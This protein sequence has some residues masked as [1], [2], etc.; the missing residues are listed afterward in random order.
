MAFL[1]AVERV[2]QIL[3]DWFSAVEFVIAC[4]L[5]TPLFAPHQNA[6]CR[7]IYLTRINK[8]K[9]RYCGDKTLKIMQGI[10]PMDL[11]ATYRRIPTGRNQVAIFAIGLRCPVR[12]FG[13]IH[14]NFCKKGL[15]VPLWGVKATHNPS[16]GFTHP[17]VFVVL[18]HRKIFP[19]TFNWLLPTLPMSFSRWSPLFTFTSLSLLHLP[20]PMTA[21]HGS[22]VL[23]RLHLSVHNEQRSCL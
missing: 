21:W 16:F 19:Y 14:L 8:H 4:R 22:K 10:C 12:G 20:S 23:P 13:C 6:P 7:W 3:L 18:L 17:Y 11:N 5:E 15:D 2:V 9:A 1:L